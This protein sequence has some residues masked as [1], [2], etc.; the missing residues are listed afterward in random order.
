MTRDQST[1]TRTYR[2]IRLGYMTG[3]QQSFLHQIKGTSSDEHCLQCL[4]LNLNASS[5]LVKAPSTQAKI[6]DA[7]V[8]YLRSAIADNAT[9]SSD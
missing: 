5:V 2:P 8:V 7:R 9:R 3:S 1:E 6:V 4:Q